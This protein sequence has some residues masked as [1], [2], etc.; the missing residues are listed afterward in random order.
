ME[1]FLAVVSSLALLIWSLLTLASA[2]GLRYGPIAPALLNL[3]I[4][5]AC[6]GATVWVGFL[7]RK[8]LS[9]QKA[10]VAQAALLFVG[11][12]NALVGWLPLLSFALAA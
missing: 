1:R 3:A 2:G 8:K 6:F 5:I 4:T 9:T 7:S 10:L 11:T 12:S